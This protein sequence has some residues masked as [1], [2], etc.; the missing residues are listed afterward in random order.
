M[1]IAISLSIPVQKKN[2]P[3]Q[4]KNVNETS[5]I[6]VIMSQLIEI[7]V[8]I[9]RVSEVCKRSRAHQLLGKIT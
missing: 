7:Q 6:S 2:V 4:K 9:C 3:V 1:S 5:A 8:L